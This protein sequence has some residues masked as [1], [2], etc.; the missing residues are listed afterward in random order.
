MAGACQGEPSRI[1]PGEATTVKVDL[2]NTGPRAGDEVVQAYIHQRVASVTR[3]VMQLAAFRRVH[4]LPGERTTVELK[5]APESMA[6]R[7][8][9][10]KPVVEPGVFDVMV[11][12][13]SAETTRVSL[14]VE[15]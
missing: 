12:P 1:R 10:M 2:T 5:L 11:G 6:L 3:P 8:P 13:S 15:K 9:D 4:L 14:H 7:G